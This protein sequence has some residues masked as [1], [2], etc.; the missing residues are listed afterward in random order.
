MHLHFIRFIWA[1]YTK[2]N[3]LKTGKKNLI[4]SGSERGFLVKYMSDVIIEIFFGKDSLIRLLEPRFTNFKVILSF[5]SFIAFLKI[6]SG[7]LVYTYFW[8]FSYYVLSS[9]AVWWTI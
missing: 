7:P 1:A 6:Q 4:F 8:F 3:K 2:N 5:Y 9:G